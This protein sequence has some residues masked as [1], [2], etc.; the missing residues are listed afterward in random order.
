MN[1]AGFTV[2]FT[3]WMEDVIDSP[4]G[5][6]RLDLKFDVTLYRHLVNTLGRQ[7]KHCDAVEYEAYKQWHFRH[8]KSCSSS[9]LLSLTR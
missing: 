5:E 8:L 7:T 6:Q 4:M 3:G 9:L 2:C 1:I